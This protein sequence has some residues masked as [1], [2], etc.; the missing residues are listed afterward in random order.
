MYYVHLK[1]AYQ[2][3]LIT[4]NPIITYTHK[5]GTSELSSRIMDIEKLESDVKALH[6]QTET[7]KAN[8]AAASA[9]ASQ[10]QE[11]KYANYVKEADKKE[12]EAEEA[13]SKR[14]IG[15]KRA[16]TTMKT[17]KQQLDGARAELQTQM[18]ERDVATKA[19]E[20]AKADVCDYLD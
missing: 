19:L 7:D 17:L 15:L 6:A 18:D 14:D 9:A 12:V 16:L 20:Q 4:H 13:A 5:T 11:D 3:P 1:P 10:A 2:H 8:S